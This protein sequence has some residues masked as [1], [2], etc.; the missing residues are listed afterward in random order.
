MSWSLSRGKPR[1]LL[2]AWIAYWTGLVLVAVGPGV[3]AILRVTPDDA[4]GSVS[5]AFGNGGVNLTVLEGAQTAWAGTA[6]L[7]AAS[8]AHVLPAVHDET[9]FGADRKA[10]RERER[11]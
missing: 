11:R 10:P 1:H 4:K 8:A 7:G 3:P 6:S 9:V 2:A 5:A